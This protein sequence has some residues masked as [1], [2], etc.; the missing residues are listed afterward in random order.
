MRGPGLRRRLRFFFPDDPFYICKTNPGVPRPT[1]KREGPALNALRID[2]AYAVR[3][4]AKRPFF[5]LVIALS[6]AVGIGL[7]TAIFSIMNAILL[8]QLPFREPARL[9]TF[10]T[11]PP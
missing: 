9:V 1:T 7:N 6:L 10:V 11:I 8:R 4:L 5:T 2:L 3:L